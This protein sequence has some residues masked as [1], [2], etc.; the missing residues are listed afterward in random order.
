[1]EFT[2]RFVGLAKDWASSEWRISLSINESG[3]I[4][5]VSKLKSCDC[6]DIKLAKHR[7]KRSKDANALLWVCITQLADALKLSKDEVYLQELK[8]YG[9]F[10]PITINKEAFETFKR[11]WREVEVVG[12][13]ENYGITKL[14]LLCY[15]GSHTYNT[16]EFSRLLEGVISDIQDIGLQPPTSQDMR[17]SLEEWERLHQ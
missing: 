15:L 11:S 5:A 13:F 9:K 10:V 1:M 16:K 14:S 3:S 4:E 12:E 17:R 8:R 2:G 6:L 7:E